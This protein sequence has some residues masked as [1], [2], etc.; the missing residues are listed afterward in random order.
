MQGTPILNGK[1]RVT[2]VTSH[3]LDLGTSLSFGVKIE[4]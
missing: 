3:L 1:A 2:K 4:I